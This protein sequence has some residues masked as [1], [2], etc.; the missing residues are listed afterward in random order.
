VDEVVHAEED[1]RRYGLATWVHDL[2]SESTRDDVR[3]RW[4]R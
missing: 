4:R 1:G 2:R 3:R